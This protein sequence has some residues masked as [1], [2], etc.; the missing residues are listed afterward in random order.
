MNEA[1]GVLPE[2]A[3]YLIKSP[4]G[5]FSVRYDWDD[6]LGHRLIDQKF[7]DLR[8]V[9]RSE[10]QQYAKLDQVNAG[11]LNANNGFYALPNYG[12]KFAPLAVDGQVD[13]TAQFFDTYGTQLPDEQNLSLDVAAETKNTVNLK[14]KNAVICIAATAE[15]EGAFIHPNN[16]PRAV[17]VGTPLLGKVPYFTSSIPELSPSEVANGNT[18]DESQFTGTRVVALGRDT[19]D[20]SSN[21]SLGSGQWNVKYQ[22]FGGQIMFHPSSADHTDQFPFQYNQSASRGYT[23]EQISSFAVLKDQ[24]RKNGTG[25]PIGMEWKHSYNPPIKPKFSDIVMDT[26][27]IR[28]SNNK[29]AIDKLFYNKG[30]EFYTSTQLDT[31]TQVVAGTGNGFVYGLRRE[32]GDVLRHVFSGDQTIGATWQSWPSLNYMN[33]WYAGAIVRFRRNSNPANNAGYDGPV[34]EFQTVSPVSPTTDFSPFTFGLYTYDE[35]PAAEFARVGLKIAMRKGNGQIWELKFNSPSNSG[36]SGLVDYMMDTLTSDVDLS[37]GQVS[38]QP[39]FYQIGFGFRKVGSVISVV[40]PFVYIDNVYMEADSDIDLRQITG[41]AG[42]LWD[43]TQAL[44]GD[45]QYFGNMGILCQS[46]QSVRTGGPAADI[47]MFNSGMAQ[48]IRPLT[49]WTG[50]LNENR[51]LFGE[52]NIVDQIGDNFDTLGTSIGYGSPIQDAQLSL[53]NVAEGSGY[54]TTIKTKGIMAYMFS[55][56]FFGALPDSV[57][58]TTNTKIRKWDANTQSYINVTMPLI[59]WIEDYYGPMYYGQTKAVAI[60][61]KINKLL[62]A[63]DRLQLS[64]KVGG[65]TKTVLSYSKNEYGGG[66]GFGFNQGVQ[67]NN[68]LTIGLQ[69]KTQ[70]TLPA[71]TG[72]YVPLD[73]EIVNFEWL[74]KQIDNQANGGQFEFTAASQFW[75]AAV[76]DDF[77][78]LETTFNAGNNFKTL[79]IPFSTHKRDK[80]QQVQVYKKLADRYVQI[81]PNSITIKDPN[82]GQPLILI[83]M[84]S[85]IDIKVQ[86]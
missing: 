18:V 34:F 72:Q 15:G 19:N 56:S 69:S 3:S 47:Y 58:E 76:A 62:V 86:L 84:S 17:P 11:Y 38:Y 78:G 33:G 70:L 55:A 39:K 81:I 16:R 66:F 10:M 42:V 9:K 59:D 2:N 37:T 67:I 31:Q 50:G 79:A 57:P 4:N 44:N 5:I 21:P 63:P 29:P 12:L 20:F 8:Y 6:Q 13:T 53:K 27:Y 43:D 30:V 73:T 48:V 14:S 23:Y 65:T 77:V 46:T 61:S 1:D 28:P 49:S 71:S 80:I 75:R 85:A 54:A 35:N 25:N 64:H 36:K 60:A 51:D 82:G 74:R 40:R 22:S 32:D 24:A 41:N 68:G 26:G 83:T 45:E 52:R 7:G